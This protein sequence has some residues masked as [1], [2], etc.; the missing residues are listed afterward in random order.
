MRLP[1]I[2]QAFLSGKRLFPSLVPIVVLLLAGWICLSCGTG[3]SH[4]N[5]GAGVRF[6]KDV[7]YDAVL[8]EGGR[9]H[10]PVV[11]YFTATWC[12]PCKVM[13][14]YVFSDENLSGRM[15]DEF[16]CV[17]MDV[18]NPSYKDLVYIYDARALPTFVIVNSKGRVLVRRTGSQSISAMHR[19]L[20]EALRIYDPE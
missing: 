14:K 10:L 9:K 12:G 4:L 17:K 18:D 19:F 13:D 5:E 1:R 3:R 6:Q 2:G 15:N 8:E 16:I 7:D 20:D 11:V